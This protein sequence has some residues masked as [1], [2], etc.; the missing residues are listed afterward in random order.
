MSKEPF[1]DAFVMKHMRTQHVFA[2]APRNNL[3][4]EK[5][6]KADWTLSVTIIKSSCGFTGLCSIIGGR[7]ADFSWVANVGGGG[8]L[9]LAELS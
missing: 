7:E 6:F 4:D 5:R 1:F 9:F 8:R 2:W 3:I